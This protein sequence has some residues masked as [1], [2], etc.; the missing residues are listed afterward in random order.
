MLKKNSFSGGTNA[1]TI[2]TGNS[3][4]TSGDAF[5]AVVG[6]PTYSSTN[7][8]GPRAPMAASVP[9]STEFSWTGLTLAARDIWIRAYVYIT[10]SPSALDFPIYSTGVARLYMDTSRRL[11][12]RKSGAGTDFALQTGSVPLNQWV[13][14]EMKWSIGTTAS[15][16]SCEIR[17]YDSADSSTP[18]ETTSAS[19]IDLGTT[20]PTDVRY[21]YTSNLTVGY[22]DIATTDVD[23]LGPASVPATVTPSNVA[24]AAAVPS[25]AVSTGSTLTP[26]PV[27]AVAAIPAPEV[28]GGATA[29]PGAVAASTTI[30]QPVLATGGNVTVSADPVAAVATVLTPAV[31]TGATATPATIAAVATVLTPHIQLPEHATVA[32]APLAVL[33]AVPPPVI[34]TPVL[35][36]AFITAPGQLEYDGFVIGTGTPY[37]LVDL[38]GFDD[39]PNADPGN[40]AEPADHGSRPGRTL[41]RDRTITWTG[42]LTCPP[43]QFEAARDALVNAT[44]YPT[45]ADDLPIA[46]RILD[47]TYLVYGKIA[48]GGRIIGLG[49]GYRF[50]YAP[51][52]LQFLCADPRVYGITIRTADLAGGGTISVL[53]AGNTE[54]RPSFRIPGPATNPQVKVVDTGRI[55]RFG[56]AL[57]PGEYID[58]DCRAGSALWMGTV[59]VL[60]SL[61]SASVTPKLFEFPPGTS[62][63][64]YAATGSSVPVV[65]VLWR[66]ATL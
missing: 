20:L 27:A 66:D 62:Q 4:G 57:A 64:T 50:G 33:V 22:D 29:T 24:A 52:A 40:S 6:S 25:P 32:P 1:A 31:Q 5:N 11:S 8:T 47:T 42:L 35:P 36:G 65:N 26:S 48:P 58:V 44:P 14:V 54:T 18:T 7:A 19:S 13:R 16:S 23:W 51:I 60:A 61:S 10:A 30:P 37:R 38:A 45:G 34:S 59:N 17:R 21:A 55:M 41:A 2:T 49:P 53:N 12:I 56:V 63:V 9:P 39:L 15:N 46:V 43:D 3:G 28:S